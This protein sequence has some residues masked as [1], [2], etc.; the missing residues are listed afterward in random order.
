MADEK[1]FSVPPVAP[2]VSTTAP[3]T[4]PLMVEKPQTLPVRKM[5][6]RQF[7]AGLVARAPVGATFQGIGAVM[8]EGGQS[9]ADAVR[10]RKE[11]YVVA[12]GVPVTGQYVNEIKAMAAGGSAIMQRTMPPQ[13]YAAAGY[14][15][16][17]PN[18]GRVGSALAGAPGFV[19]PAVKRMSSYIPVSVAD[20]RRRQVATLMGLGSL[21]GEFPDTSSRKYAD[22]DWFAKNSDRSGCWFSATETSD[23]N[24]TFLSD[25]TVPTSVARKWA[26]YC[27]ETY[28]AD[29]T[30]RRLCKIV[31][32]VAVTPP[33]STVGRV[34][35]GLPA[36]LKQVATDVTQ[37]AK[38]IKAAADTAAPPPPQA[39]PPVNMTQL[40]PQTA[41]RKIPDIFGA[42]RPPIVLVPDIRIQPPPPKKEEPKSNTALI[43]GGLAVAAVV[44][45]MVFKKK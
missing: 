3:T 36:D 40:P 6:P 21:A 17:D 38:D 33:W 35:R 10:A 27:D 19:P 23:A 12:D 28:S 14:R 11:G 15:F 41:V 4:S 22:G 43:V 31:P 16:A 20:E 26:K 44:G 32:D 9:V 13:G 30:L 25:C 29:A 8:A 24:Q 18:R 7:S 34:Q 1:T 45:V 42:K 2:V 39:Q 5:A 37:A